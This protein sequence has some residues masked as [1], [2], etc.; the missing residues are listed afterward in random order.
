MNESTDKLLEARIGDMIERCGRG[1]GFSFSQFLDERQ[2]AEA[3]RICS[4]SVGGSLRYRLFGGF[5]GS[6]RKMLCIY[7]DYCEDY[8]TDEFPMRC[9]T[10]V[11]RK[12]DRLNHRDFLGSLMGLRLKREVIGDIIIAEG[13]AQIFVTETAA[14][15]IMSD[16][17][18]IGRVGVRIS[19]DRPFEI[20]VRQEF[21]EFGSTVASL[22]LDCI[23]SAAAKVSREA[24]ARLIRSEK[25]SV[26]H[27]SSTSLSQELKEG[28]VISVRGSG[29]FIFAKIGDTT[30]KERIHIILR[31]YK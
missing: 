15:L 9:L 11:F 8:I 1:C 14:R 6:A 5:D 16:L 7:E 30:K 26:N 22:R 23:V 31:K 4:H 2:C 19:D 24:A 21:D 18:K 3:E 10:F 13:I 12:E 17:K 29:R 27:F 20:E 28:D 25:V